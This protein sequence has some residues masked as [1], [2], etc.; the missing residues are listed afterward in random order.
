MSMQVALAGAIW[1]IDN[2]QK[3]G[4]VGKKAH[5]RLQQLILE[6]S[7]H[8][9]A[10]NDAPLTLPATELIRMV[11][12]FSLLPETALQA[13]G[14][15]AAVV[16]FLPGDTVTKEAD[17]GN[18]LYIISQGAVE[19]SHLDAD[20]HSTKLAEL[21]A[22]DFFGEMALLEDQVRKATVKAQLPST[23]LRLTRKDV[24]RL[25]SEHPEV[26]QRLNEAKEDRQHTLG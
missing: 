9:P 10:V 6:A 12:M 19:V 15:H 13:L 21:R 17:K 2:D 26:E 18:A 20:F 8:I 1:Q 24:L 14:S 7:K 16:T 11:P 3:H 5:Y 22:G 23:L 25:A 4:E